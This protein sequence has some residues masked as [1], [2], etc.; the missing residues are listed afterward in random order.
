MLLNLAQ[1][2]HLCTGLCRIEHLSW[3]VSSLTASTRP[4][5][6]TPSLRDLPGQNRFVRHKIRFHCCHLPLFYNVR[7]KGG[8]S[9][10]MN[11][12]TS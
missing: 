3:C 5:L 10:R 12:W 4:N 11:K 6:S 2:A 7:D 8:V 9:V 1:V